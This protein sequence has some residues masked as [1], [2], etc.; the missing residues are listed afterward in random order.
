LLLISGDLDQHVPVS[1]T[2]SLVN[3]LIEANRDFDLLIVPNEGHFVLLRSGYAQRRIWD[4]LVEHLLELEPPPSFPVSFT[5]D[6][7]ERA[8]QQFLR[9]VQE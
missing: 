8:Y 3:A 6:E 4:F 5:E 1:N 7:A 2:L 9:E